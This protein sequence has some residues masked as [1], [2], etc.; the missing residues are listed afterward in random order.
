MIERSTIIDYLKNKLEPLEYVY[1]MWLEGAD[2][3]GTLDKYSDIDIC[4]D[5]KD[6][7][8]SEAIKIV[9]DAL[10]EIG[11]V[12]YKYVMHNGHPKLRQ[13][14]YHLKDTSEYLMIDFCWQLHSRDRDEYVYIVGNNIEAAKVLFDKDNIIRYKELDLQDYDEYNVR[15]LEECKYR[16]TQHCRVTKYVLRRQFPEAYVYYNR[17]VVEPLIDLLRLKYTPSHAHFHLIHISSHIPE[18][19]RIKLEYFLKISSLEDISRKIPEAQEWFEELFA[20]LAS[21]VKKY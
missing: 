15:R 14:I 13:R 20:N 1:A 4:I 7:K 12:D 3:N 19:D 16:Y 11:E 8:E 17:Y 10:N 5:I 2:A 6:E 9:E 21:H 18:N